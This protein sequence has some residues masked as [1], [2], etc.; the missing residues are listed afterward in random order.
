[1]AKRR[2]S[3]I[4]LGNTRRQKNQTL[5][6]LGI[7]V[8]ILLVV[9]LLSLCLVGWLLREDL[10][11]PGFG[12]H[13]EP[14]IPASAD[15]DT[16]AVTDLSTEAPVTAIPEKETEK[17]PVTEAPEETE[18]IKEI[19]SGIPITGAPIKVLDYTDTWVVMLDPGHGFDDV[20]TTSELLGGVN[21]AT[22]NLDIALRMR[23]ELQKAGVTV[24]MTHDDN[25]VAGRV[26]TADGGEPPLHDLV[27]LPPE[28]RAVLANGQDI[29]LYVSIH[30][31]AMPEN[32]DAGGMRAYYHK[33]P[34]YPT[35]R[36]S[37]AEAL[38]CSLADSFD[39]GMNETTPLVK[40]LPAEDA[41]YVIRFIEVP[42]VLCET[43]FVTNAEDAASLLDPAWRQAA[44]EALADG[45]LRYIQGA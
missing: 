2:G 35:V 24:L 28:D 36:N 3:G 9:V 1:M 12:D 10:R 18:P 38:A 31:D 43:G 42:S 45:I 15:T 16:E 20:G 11:L 29:D 34:D 7:L 23:D 32:G 37:A 41:Y 17:F 22:I 40:M 14:E 33:N 4:Y 6:N 5:R 13:D 44:A 19:H 26:S 25:A 30:C 21:E 8:S 27:L 39:R